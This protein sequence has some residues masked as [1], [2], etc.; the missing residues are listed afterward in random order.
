MKMEKW[1]VSCLLFG[2][3][4]VDVMRGMNKVEIFQLLIICK[5]AAREKNG[6]GKRQRKK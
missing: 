5:S 4:H 1:G 6:G 3:I 2:E